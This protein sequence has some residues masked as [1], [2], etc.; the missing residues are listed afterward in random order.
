VWLGEHRLSRPTADPADSP[1]EKLQQAWDWLDSQRD[2]I[3]HTLFRWC[4]QNSWSYNPVGLSAMAKMLHD[5][6]EPLKLDFEQVELPQLVRGRTPTAAQTS[7]LTGP[8]LLWHHLPHATTRVLLLIHYDTVYQPL[9]QRSVEIQ[10]PADCGDIIGVGRG[11]RLIGPGVAD[12]KGGIAVIRYAI[13][14]LLR[15]GLSGELGW[16]VALNPDEEIGSP[17]SA[18]WLAQLAPNFKFGLVF[19]PTLSDGAMV[20][21]RKGSGNWRY[22]VNGRSAHAGRNPEQGRN[23]IV[24]AARLVLELDRI[25]DP[26]AGL[27]LN[28]GRIDGGGALNQ[29]PDG[30]TV[31]LNVR[32]VDDAQA[33]AVESRLNDL[34]VQ[35]AQVDG[36]RCSLEGGFTSPPKRHDDRYRPLRAMFQRAAGLIGRNVEWRDT[37]GACDGSKLAAAGLVNID[38][39]GPTG[40]ELHSFDE[41]CDL[42]SVLTA[43]KTLVNLMAITAAVRK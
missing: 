43:A 2:G 1:I 41:Y 18:P 22:L 36:Y 14:A 40:G 5:D 4:E 19:E 38:T 37:G 12:A 7:Q 24:H 9:A 25:S 35:F 3:C 26:A 33:A 15:F 21:N 27:T 42:D 29:V 10:G 31:E 28:V 34:A 30:A 11:Q 6:F 32:V 17:S 39:M 16:T 23:A 8:G 13:E 20:A